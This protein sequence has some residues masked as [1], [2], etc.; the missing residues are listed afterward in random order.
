MPLLKIPMGPRSVGMGGAYTAVAQGPESLWWNPAGL[1]GSS[2]TT[3][4]FENSFIMEDLLLDTLAC[5]IPLDTGDALGLMVTR[6]GFN[7]PMPGYDNTG[8]ETADVEFSEMLFAAGY[9]TDAFEMPFGFVIKILTSKLANVSAVSFAGDLGV[10]QD[11]LKQDLTVGLSLKNIGQKVKY[12][13]TGFP[14][15]FTV[16]LGAAYRLLGQDLVLAG[17]VQMP[18]DQVPHYHVGVEFTRKLQLTFQ[19]AVRA[20]F[21]TN[22]AQNLEAMNGL[23][24][25]LSIDWRFNQRTLARTGRMVGYKEALLFLLGLDY[26]WVPNSE[27]GASHRV[28]VRFEF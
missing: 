13:T 2:T 6:L 16:N 8:L 26:A 22:Y 5:Q 28:S 14:L 1:I 11:F 21:N 3:I 27:L 19:L 18:F 15:P 12:E 9:G 7:Q 17:D 25:G 10:R 23:N 20:G 24:A 4:L